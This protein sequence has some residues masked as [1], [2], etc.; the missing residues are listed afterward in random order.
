MGLIFNDKDWDKGHYYLSFPDNGS[1]L[2]TN[3]V[4]C[5]GGG[6]IGRGGED[7]EIA[8][9][10]EAGLGPLMPM[11][12]EASAAARGAP[13]AD[14]TAQL[15][16]ARMAGG[17]SRSGGI[18]TPPVDDD[19]GEIAPVR[20]R[21]EGSAPRSAGHRGLRNIGV[22]HCANPVVARSWGMGEED[23]AEAIA[24]RKS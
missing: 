20:C 24:N 17:C 4:A 13:R 8:A 1:V 14:T 18:T 11:A 5:L 6:F 10:V 16:P 9:A 19:V 2:F 3:V 7:P 15:A 12:V 23:T 21:Q 22:R